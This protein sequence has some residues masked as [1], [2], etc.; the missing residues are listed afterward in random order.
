[1]RR[2]LLAFVVAAAVA[3][4]ALP[5][6]AAW[7]DGSILV[8]TYADAWESSTELDAFGEA[9]GRRVALAGTFHHIHEG[10]D[11]TFFILEQVWQAEATPFANLEAPVSAADLAS[12]AYDAALG[13]W[14]ESVSRWLAQG[15]GRSLFVAPL[16]EMNGDWIPWGMDPESYKS[17]FRKIVAAFESRGIGDS[18]VR[19][20]FAPNGWS[21]PPY[22]MADYYPGDDAVDVVGFSAYNHG[23]LRSWA[24]P[25]E[26]VTPALREIHALAP[27]KPVFFAQVGSAAAGGDRDRWVRELFHLA[28]EDPNV[29]G[30]V[31]FNLDRETDWRVFDGIRVAPGWAES[32]A[33]PSIRYAWPLSDWFR[34]GPL[35]EPVPLDPVLSFA[36]CAASSPYPPAPFPDV[37]AGAWYRRAVDWAAASDISSGHTDG[38]FRPLSPVSRAEAAAFLS[39]LTCTLPGG[40]APFVD[41]PPDAWYSSPVGW[42]ATSGITAGFGDGTFRPGAPVTRGEL[43]TFLWRIAGAPPHPD[44]APFRDV[45]TGSWASPAVSWAAVHGVVEGYPDGTFRPD[46][47]V[48]RAETVTLLRRFAVTR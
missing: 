33:R 43:A 31:Y 26:V 41:V 3:V 32:V 35:P 46:D 45:P 9:S 20:V 18:Q 4:P 17:V 13:E 1:M 21:S 19:W 39:R 40:A 2:R 23:S 48:S 30:I 16:P 14:V 7:V 42:M 22:R 8:G 24:D 15:G 25:W 29:A 34:P 12:G 37:E 28:E 27:S 36:V 10:F 5:A 44:A 11:N 47:P 38:T 6:G